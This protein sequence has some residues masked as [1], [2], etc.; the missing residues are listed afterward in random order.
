MFVDRNSKKI[1]KH[2]YTIFKS[3][4][5]VGNENNKNKA[6]NFTHKHFENKQDT[7]QTLTLYMYMVFSLFPKNLFPFIC[8]TKRTSRTNKP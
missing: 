8:P 5:Q 6:S 7:I 2:F 1:L 4:L 3:F